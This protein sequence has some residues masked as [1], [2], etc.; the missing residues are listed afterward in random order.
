MSRIFSGWLLLAA[1]AVVG[2]AV[3]IEGGPGRRTA[4]GYAGVPPCTAMPSGLV[5]WWQANGTYEDI[6]SGFDGAPQGSVTHAPGYVGQAFTFERDNAADYVAVG[7]PVELAVVPAGVTVEAWINLESVPSTGESLEDRPYGIATKINHTN[8][9]N[10]YGL[11]VSNTGAGATLVASI[12]NGGTESGLAGGTLSTSTWHH[13]ATTYDTT[14]D[15][16][17]IYVDG[18]EVGSRTR[19][20]G[21]ILTSVSF[22]IGRQ[23]GSFPRYFDGLIDDARVYNRA[24]S[25][26]ELDAIVLAGTAGMCNPPPPPACIAAPSDLISWW[27][28]NNSTVDIVS[29][30]D[31][32]LKNGATFG[33]GHVRAAF[34]LE[35]TTN[36]YVEV[37]NHPALS[38]LPNGVTLEAWINLESTPAV[39]SGSAG[40]MYGIITKWGQ[41]VAGD[42]YGMYAANVSG[43]V[44]ILGGIG[45]GG[46]ASPEFHGG[47]LIPGTW[48]H[49]AMTYDTATDV[50]KLY[51][52]GIE[53]A[54]RI[55][56]G[57]INV[58]TRKTLIGREDSTVPRNFDGRIDDARIY[59][60]ALSGAELSA[61]H[62]AGAGGVCSG[63]GSITIRK[64][65][66]PDGSAQTF[67]FTGDVV[68]TIGDGATLTSGPVAAGT[69]TVVETLPASPWQLQSIVCDDSDSTGSLATRTATIN[70]GAGEDVE[71]VFTNAIPP[72]LPPDWLTTD[73]RWCKSPNPDIWVPVATTPCG[74]LTQALPFGSV[75]NVDGAA[76]LARGVGRA[77]P[78]YWTGDAFFPASGDF[79]MTLRMKYDSLQPHGTGV[80]FFKWDDA[81]PTGSNSPYWGGAQS[82]PSWGVWGGGG[83]ASY[84]FAGTALGLS[85]PTTYHTFKMEYIDSANPAGGQYLLFVDGVLRIGPV[86]TTVRANRAWAGNPVF[87]TWASL[88]WTDFTIQALSA[89]QPALFDGNNNSID[90]RSETFAPTNVAANTQVDTDSDG[91]P[92]HCDPST[93]P[94]PPGTIVIRKETIP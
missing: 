33:T 60:R 23:A 61:L 9:G 69:Y 86:R 28:G 20:G 5:S 34:D 53:V 51:V 32:T 6:V 15:I 27:P 62:A 54:S 45:I 73:N 81:T 3:A 59:G 91:M 65:T 48:H 64:E 85:S 31:G 80:R 35:R 88:D 56:A 30:L 11:L 71:C 58:S 17:K 4:V 90:D 46:T 63:P 68:G 42:A 82:C 22:L 84:S 70:V 67:D 25:E 89:T 47:T 78:Y 38:T 40:Q 39:N 92:D 87:T 49:V 8:S 10:Q 55:R 66:E 79:V 43:T 77:F 2:M 13:V 50:N 57:G 1:L 41:T 7:N 52:D 74:G 18:V 72:L 26:P 14:T 29:G 83:G 16:N 44:R 93:T 36:Q 24:L 37:G 76:K 21:I 19:A 94:P 75:T 12:G